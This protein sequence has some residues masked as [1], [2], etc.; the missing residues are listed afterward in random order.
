M[1][2]RPTDLEPRKRGDPEFHL[3]AM[4]DGIDRWALNP[5]DTRWI[6]RARKFD[7]VVL[8]D[9]VTLGWRPAMIITVASAVTTVGWLLALGATHN[10]FLRTVLAILAVIT[11]V[12]AAWLIFERLW[13]KDRYVSIGSSG[14]TVH[15]RAA[16]DV[17]LSWIEIKRVRIITSTYHR[18]LPRPSEVLPDGS[19]VVAR[20]RILLSP[21]LPDGFA[22]HKSANLLRYD[23]WRP[24]LR[25]LLRRPGA[26]RDQAPTQ[27]RWV[28]LR[29][30]TLIDRNCIPVPVLLADEA[31]RRFAGHRY[32][33]RPT[34]ERCRM[35]ALWWP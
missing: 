24:M 35:S 3:V 20:T 14:I 21:E 27:R 12:P 13:N 9:D 30:R 2:R 22:T 19:K 32:A 7:P 23:R 18:V 11:C 33:G 34:A 25:A 15:R 10:T 28:V 1:S 29:H 16:G 5:H 26:P 17:H 31:M 8:T 6:K 4:R